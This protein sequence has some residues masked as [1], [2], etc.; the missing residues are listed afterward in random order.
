MCVHTLYCFFVSIHVSHWII[1]QMEI[2]LT[3]TLL[4][5]EAEL[6]PRQMQ[7]Q[8]P[9]EHA[10]PNRRLPRC[11]NR[12]LRVKYHHLQ[13]TDFPL[14]DAG[15]FLSPYISVE[16]DPWCNKRSNLVPSCWTWLIRPGHEKMCPL[17]ALRIISNLELSCARSYFDI[18]YFPQV[19]STVN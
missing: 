4:I 13:L 18:T 10:C 14:E 2:C 12:T 15:C 8:I 19:C 7:M 16:R 6:Y 1:R 5:P 3:L 9:Q 17:D 11:K